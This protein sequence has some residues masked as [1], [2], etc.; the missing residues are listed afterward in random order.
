MAEEDITGI[1]KRSLVAGSIAGCSVDLS[2][3]PID[4]IK[5]RLQQ[6]K[7]LTRGFLFSSLYSGVG[8]VLIGSGPSSA[9][10]FTAYNL[11][12]Q[13]IQFS[14]QWQTHMT[15]A[16]LGEI[17]ACLI[18]VP[19]EV[20]KQRAQVNRNLSLLTITRSCFQ[21]EGLFG[22]YRGYFATVTR[23]IPFSIIQFPLWELFKEYWSTK[24]GYPVAPWQGALCGSIS[25][26]IAASITTPLDV[27]KTRIMLAHHSDIDAASNSFTVM[28]NIVK[29][30]GFTAGVLPRTMWISIGGL[31]YFG[32]FEYVTSLFFSKKT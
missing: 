4:T 16:T 11:S 13:T 30:E 9:L 25:G 24:Q 31:I 1:I 19:V 2:L 6:K 26:G 29:N 20:V 3:Y 22:L 10:F 21:N 28:K 12:K 32:A 17:C 23:E 5:T 27:A 14:S 8:S 7:S 18:R 15:A